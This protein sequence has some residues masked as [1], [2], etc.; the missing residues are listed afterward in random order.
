[1]AGPRTRQ[2][3][4]TCTARTSKHLERAAGNPPRWS[5]MPEPAPRSST[6]ASWSPDQVKDESPAIE[7]IARKRPPRRFRTSS[8]DA[9]TTRSKAL[10]SWRESWT[11]KRMKAQGRNGRRRLATSFC[12]T[13]SNADQDPEV[14]QPRSKRQRASDARRTKQQRRTSNGKPEQ[15]RQQRREGTAQGTITSVIALAGRGSWR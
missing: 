5:L 10:E 15:L 7:E 3:G 13:D 12:A 8:E 14:E 11:T 9:T 4:Q 1:M 2:R 6:A